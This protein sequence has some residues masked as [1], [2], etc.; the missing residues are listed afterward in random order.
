MS[1]DASR[2][3]GNSKIQERLNP[4]S[5]VAATMSIRNS[6]GVN[7]AVF[8]NGQTDFVASHQMAAVEALRLLVNPAKRRKNKPPI[9]ISVKDGDD[10]TEQV[11]LTVGLSPIGGNLWSLA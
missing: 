10:R 7:G 2:L 6:N 8:E 5:L 3:L 1:A 4:L 9:I 11:L